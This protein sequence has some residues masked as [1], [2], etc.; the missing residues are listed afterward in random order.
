MTIHIEV[1]GRK[2]PFRLDWEELRW[3]ALEEQKESDFPLITEVS[4]KRYELYSDQT[5]AEVEK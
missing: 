4:G 3:N 5:F 1:E 2:I